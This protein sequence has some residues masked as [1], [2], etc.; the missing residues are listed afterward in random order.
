MNTII[1]NNITLSLAEIEIK[2]G[3]SAGQKYNGVLDESVTIENITTFL[4]IDEAKSA[5]V[6]KANYYIR[7][8]QASGEDDFSTW[9]SSNGHKG[10]QADPFNAIMK[11]IKEAQKAGDFTLVMNLMEQMKTIVAAKV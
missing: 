8:F 10:R 2:A 6:E 11:Q 7:A 4:G 5:L 3:R 9:F 1:N